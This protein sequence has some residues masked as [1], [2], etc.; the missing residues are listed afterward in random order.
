LDDLDFIPLTAVDRVR[1]EE[2]QAMRM[3]LLQVI[4]DLVIERVPDEEKVPLFERAYGQL[5]QAG[6]GLDELIEAAEPGPRRDHLFAL[7]G[8]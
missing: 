5:D 2:K 1:P 7:L 3:A 4:Q 8:L 6:W